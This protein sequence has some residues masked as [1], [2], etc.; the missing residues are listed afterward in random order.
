MPPPAQPLDV[1]GSKQLVA[2]VDDVAISSAAALIRGSPA[3]EDL[4]SWLIDDYNQA[5]DLSMMQG[6]SQLGAPASDI[7]MSVVAGRQ[8]QS[9]A[10]ENI[11]ADESDQVDLTSPVAAEG[12]IHNLAAFDS[13]I[14]LSP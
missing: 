11:L 10:V 4:T 8:V 9:A 3:A 6:N 14:T 2:G 12:S 1:A 13:D 7:N 5:E